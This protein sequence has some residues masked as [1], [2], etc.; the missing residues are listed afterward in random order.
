MTKLAAG[1]SLV[2]L[3]ALL[4]ACSGGNDAPP[5][6]IYPPFINI[7]GDLTLNGATSVRGNISDCAGAARYADLAKKAPVTVSSASG[8]PLAV[9]AIAYAVG[10]NVYRNQLDQCTFRYNVFHVPRAGTYQITIGR[11]KPFLAKFLTLLHTRGVM[12][13]ELPPT[14][15]PTTTTF[16]PVPT[17][18]P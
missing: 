13:V 15:V 1:V 8:V 6:P 18:K 9:G 4:G 3:V 12:N 5:K 7:S 16:L 10:T 11:Q 17:S 14:T 2:V